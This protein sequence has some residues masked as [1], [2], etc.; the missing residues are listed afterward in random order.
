VFNTLK[1]K[2]SGVVSKKI[3]LDKLD[4]LSDNNPFRQK[5][6]NKNIQEYEEKFECLR[7]Y[8]NENSFAIDAANI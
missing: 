5:Y 7:D 8:I 6:E 1:N 4:V 3:V 2:I